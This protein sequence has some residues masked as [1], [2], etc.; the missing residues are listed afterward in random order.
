MYY[1]VLSVDVPTQA[2][3]ANVGGK[4]KTSTC[5]SYPFYH[6][7]RENRKERLRID[8]NSCERCKEYTTRTHHKDG[9]RYNHSLDNIAVDCGR[10]HKIGH[11]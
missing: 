9:T 11:N 7:Y 3:I 1:K 2:V 8:N 10:C 4:V 6:V 5:Q